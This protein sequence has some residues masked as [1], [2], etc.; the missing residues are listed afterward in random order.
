MRECERGQAGSGR[1]MIAVWTGRFACRLH[2][3]KSEV[4]VCLL[5][6]CFLESAPFHAGSFLDERGALVAIDVDGGSCDVGSVILCVS[7][8]LKQPQ[9]FIRASDLM[10]CMR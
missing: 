8:C 9:M 1:C 10:S 7:S 6:R 3:G 2:R 5:V 4:R